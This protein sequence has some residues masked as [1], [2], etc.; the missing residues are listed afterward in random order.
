[1]NLLSKVLLGCLVAGAV[2]HFHDDNH[3]DHRHLDGSTGCMTKEPSGADGHKQEVAATLQKLKQRKQ[4]GYHANTQKI[5]PVCFHITTGDSRFSP[6]YITKWDLQ[7]QLDALNKA[8]SADSCCDESLE[9]CDPSQCS[10]DTNIYFVMQHCWFFGLFCFSGSFTWFG[11]LHGGACIRRTSRDIPLDRYPG[12][13]NL[14][15]IGNG[16]VLNIYISNFEDDE[17]LGFGT[18]P[19]ETLTDTIKLRE[20]GVVINIKARAGGSL[21]GHNEGDVLVHMVG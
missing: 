10:L 3:H 18:P 16:D 19:Y 4:S 9:W 11:A 6:N 15:H 2:A 1:M 12:A 7:R 21:D 13:M 17:N 20:D 5:V 14:Q 8:F